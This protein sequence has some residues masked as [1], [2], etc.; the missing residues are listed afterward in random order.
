MDEESTRIQPRRQV[1]RY[2]KARVEVVSGADGGLVYDV[3][4]S[5]VR[6]GASRSSNDL[7]LTD[8]TVSRHHLELSPT[9][10]GVRV[11]DAGSTNGVFANGVRV[12]DAV[13]SEN[14]DLQLGS[15][16][17]RVTLLPDGTDRELSDTHRFG[18]LLGSS[19]RMRA[20]F[21][22]LERIAP[23][24]VSLL[25]EGETGTG[26][27]VVAESVHR[28]SA[29]AGGPFVVFDC[30]AVV[31]TLVESA[32]FG[33][34]RGAFTGAHSAHVGVFEQ[35]HGGTIFLDELGELPLELQKRLLRVLQSREVVRLG[36]QR[37]TPVDVRVI[38]ATNRNLMQEV[39]KGRFREDLY[40][41][42]AAMHVVVPPLRERLEDLP[43]LVEHFLAQAEPPQ[44]ASGI[45]SDVWAMFRAHRWP[46]NVRELQNV[47]QRF[48]VMPERLF[49]SAPASAAAPAE[50]PA[51]P[52][53]S[54]RRIEPLQ[55]A[56]RKASETFERD[57]LDELMRQA[58]GNVNAAA[59]LA[60]VS[61]Q[62]LYKMLRKQRIDAPA[63]DDGSDLES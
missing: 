59:G 17:L 44:S 21:A 45:P 39:Q 30:S 28:K 34:E 33:H 16:V 27:E 9:P 63:P 62:M 54:P 37:S 56:R 8:E 3:N 18:D 7:V 6:V 20:L 11:R 2:T 57:Y 22:D 43:K 48:V 24:D 36:A 55:V 14:V 53:P 12:F 50:P 26:K 52:A 32:L 13:F 49:P 29:R 58:N 46:G 23:K 1:V 15:T 38:A 41:R 31:P 10:H 4:D 35:A 25:I 42:I 19:P 40:Y 47:L 61:R 51:V 5:S 60:E